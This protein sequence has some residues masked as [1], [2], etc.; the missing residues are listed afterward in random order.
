MLNA[1]RIFTISVAFYGN[2]DTFSDF[3]KIQDFFKKLIF[4][5]K[6]T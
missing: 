1:L 5:L 3:E 2:F 6:K 4:F